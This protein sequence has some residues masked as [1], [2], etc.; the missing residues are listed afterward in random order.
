MDLDRLYKLSKTIAIFALALLL[1]SA[2]VKMWCGKHRGWHGKY[3][4][5]FVTDNIEFKSYVLNS[6]SGKIDI[7]TILEGEDVKGEIK[8]ILNKVIEDVDIDNDGEN[9]IKKK[10]IVKVIEE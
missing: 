10:V 8:D 3:G 4:R 7:E 5:G 6:D 1:I 2:T 9:K